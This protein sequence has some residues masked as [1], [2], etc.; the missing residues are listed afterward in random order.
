MNTI[1]RNLLVVITIGMLFGCTSSQAFSVVDRTTDYPAWY[2]DP[3]SVYPK[4]NYL[5]AVGSGDT[6]R[7]A[8]EQALTVLAQLFKT[9]VEVDYQV[10]ERYQEIITATGVLTKEEMELSKK[11]SFKSDEELL[12]VRFGEAAVDTQGQVYTIAYLDRIET[13][14]IYLNIIR[15]NSAGIERL[16]AQAAHTSDILDRHAAISAAVVI[17]AGNE[18]LAEQLQIISPSMMMMATSGYNYQQL[19][20]QQAELITQLRVKLS[21]S[22]DYYGRLSGVVA[23]A[24]SVEGYLI[25][26]ESAVMVVSGELKLVPVVLNPEF[27]TVRWILIL[28]ASKPDGTIIA[29]YDS[30]GRASGITDDAAASFA[31][32]DIRTVIETEFMQK[33]RT[34]I[35]QKVFGTADNSP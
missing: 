2:L 19:L 1:I 31:Y 27:K 22:G 30:Q 23:Q 25:S 20:A 3:D 9:R 29:A 21:L 15:K 10:Q 16:I 14:K 32:Q 35:D 17:A 8:E 6:R 11:S 28:T 13:G 18:V 33:I 34:T 12:N 26:S 5:A 24:L 4:Q 7:D